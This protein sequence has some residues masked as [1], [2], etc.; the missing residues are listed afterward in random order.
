M[1]KTRD[2]RRIYVGIELFF[3]PVQEGD[4]ILKNPDL[5]YTYD[6]QNGEEGKRFLLLWDVDC[7]PKEIQAQTQL[8]YYTMCDSLFGNI[9]P[10]C[11]PKNIP[12]L[13]F[14]CIVPSN[15]SDRKPYDKGWSFP[16]FRWEAASIIFSACSTLGEGIQ[17]ITHEDF[18]DYFRERNLQ[19]EEPRWIMTEKGYKKALKRF[20]NRAM[21]LLKAINDV[22]SYALFMPQ[23]E[24]ILFH[25]DALSYHLPQKIW[26]GSTRRTELMRVGLHF[27]PWFKESEVRQRFYP[28]GLMLMRKG[29][30]YYLYDYEGGRWL[31]YNKEQNCVE[32]TSRESEAL[33]YHPEKQIHILPKGNNCRPN[34]LLRNGKRL[35]IYAN[36]APSF[37]YT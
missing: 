15:L 13:R 26:G 18:D 30:R 31:K 22:Q 32:E 1:M 11:H 10:K 35:H 2:K 4:Y 24:Q 8:Y 14:V 23:Y 17:C 21:T 7:S 29:K 37:C 9:S 20:E 27:Q 34:Y 12:I 25:M 28:G 5:Y 19:Q 3:L 36:I 16:A 33:P 6:P